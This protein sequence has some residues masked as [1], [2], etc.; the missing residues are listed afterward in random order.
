METGFY[1]CK[2]LDFPRFQL[3]LK[4]LLLLENI[5]RFGG[6]ARTSWEKVHLNSEAHQ[7]EHNT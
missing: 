2:C 3:E 4:D 7:R 6:G 1:D 5:Q